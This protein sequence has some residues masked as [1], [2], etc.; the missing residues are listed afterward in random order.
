MATTMTFSSTE[1]LVAKTYCKFRTYSIE[2]F[3]SAFSGIFYEQM[4]ALILS[5]SL[6]LDE[7]Q[8]FKACQYN[9]SSIFIRQLQS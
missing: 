9:E 7:K 1:I 6:E 8:T 5:R 2:I 4:V 3:T